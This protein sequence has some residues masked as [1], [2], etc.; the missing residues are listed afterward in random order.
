MPGESAKKLV[1]AIAEMSNIPMIAV[2]SSMKVVQIVVF[3]R[4]LYILSYYKR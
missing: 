4:C 2:R 1:A 3:L